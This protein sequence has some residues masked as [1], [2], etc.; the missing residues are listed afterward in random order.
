VYSR[1]EILNVLNAEYLR[2]EKIVNQK[3]GGMLAY[4]SE[5][6]DKEAHYNCKRA[7]EHLNIKYNKAKQQD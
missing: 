5:L 2:L 7:I 1:E 6:S 3:A 4:E